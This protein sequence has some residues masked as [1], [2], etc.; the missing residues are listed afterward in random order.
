MFV[1][2]VAVFA[3]AGAGGLGGQEAVA[4]KYLEWAKAEAEKG[5]AEKA[6]KALLRALDYADVSSDLPFELARVQRTL[7][8]PREEALSNTE[9][10]I[11][12]GRWRQAAEEDAF[13]LK[14]EL[15]IELMDYDAAFRVIR[16]LPQSA[17]REVLLLR[18]FLGL[19]D[20]PSFRI[21]ARDALRKYPDNTEIAALIFRFAAL[22]SAPVDGRRPVLSAED[23]EL[24]GDALKILDA[25]MAASP[26][27]IYLAAP[28]MYDTAEA[29][30]LLTSVSLNGAAAPRDALPVLLNLGV[31]NEETAISILFPEDNAAA[32]SGSAYSGTA[33]SGA[34]YSGSAASGQAAVISRKT[35][36]AVYSLLRTEEARSSFIRRLAV[37][38]GIITG[39]RND[40]GIADSETLYREGVPFVHKDDSRQKGV[41][42]LTVYWEADRVKEAVIQPWSRQG[43]S[44]GASSHIKVWYDSY[45]AAVCAEVDSFNIKDKTGLKITK[46]FFRPDDFYYAPVS[47]GVLCGGGILWPEPDYTGDALN[48]TALV[49]FASAIESGSA[50]FPGATE[51]KRLSDGVIL[52]SVTILNGRTISE[53]RYKNGL[54]YLEL[55]DTDLDGILETKRYFKTNGSGRPVIDRTESDW[56]A[57]PQEEMRDER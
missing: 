57:D 44:L 4:D 50:E 54:P 27:I 19:R 24:A 8:R 22:R 45:P 38:G 26:E 13:A 10:A 56:A 9:L 16:R 47:F 29:R 23:T 15:L 53:T 46:Y 33:A 3:A 2:L 5:N 52:S 41:P 51:T 40:D 37:F 30:R 32:A 14:A 20:F 34:A 49:A 35:L 48:E 25:L 18:A 43:A 55:V 36:E 31:I 28:F 6:E 21:N 7:N 12:T 42:R 39:D 1:I 17:A 11:V